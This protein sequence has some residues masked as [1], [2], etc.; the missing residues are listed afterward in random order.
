MTRKSG[1]KSVNSAWIFCEG[2][3]E[4][5]YFLQYRAVE[6]IQGL[7][8]KPKISEDKNIVGLIEYSMDF[9]KH[10]H[11][12]FL[13]GD[14]I[15][16]VF[17]MDANTNEDFIKAKGLVNDPN[18][19][20][21]LSNPCFEVWI[22][23]HFEFHRERLYPELLKAKLLRHLGSYKKNDP[24]IYQNTKEKINIAIGN[25]KRIY[26]IQIDKNG[27]LCEESNPSTMMFQLIEIIRESN[28]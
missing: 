25:S 26:Q 6:R 17:D 1:K 18:L 2:K 3:T 19:Q 5:N 20:F 24:N 14:L 23:S 28:R 16:Y 4:Y 21:I 22:L 11:R 15:F 10:H 12:D 7:Q 8:I 9:R 27:I 13:K